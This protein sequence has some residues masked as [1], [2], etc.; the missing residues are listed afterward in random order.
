MNI[1]QYF[2]LVAFLI[3][4][5]KSFN[6][7]IDA[8]KK[9]LQD[10]Y[11]PVTV[12][13]SA[14]N[15]SIAPQ[16]FLKGKEEIE[17]INFKDLHKKIELELPD[18][19][20]PTDKWS[21]LEFNENILNNIL[22]ILQDF[23]V[24]YTSKI[25]KQIYSNIEQFVFKCMVYKRQKCLN[26]KEFRKILENITEK[27]KEMMKFGILWLPISEFYDFNLNILLSK[28]LLSE[29]FIVE[30]LD[31]ENE[32]FNK[33]D[34]IIK[35]F[36]QNGKDCNNIRKKWFNGNFNNKP[37]LAFMILMYDDGTANCFSKLH[38]PEP[39][40]QRISDIKAIKSKVVEGFFNYQLVTRRIFDFYKNNKFRF[41]IK[42]SIDLWKLLYEM[43]KL[44]ILTRENLVETLEFPKIKS[45][46]WNQEE[47]D[48]H[49]K[50]IDSYHNKLL[51]EKVKK[52]FE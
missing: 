47:F 2:I 10:D 43:D 1:I 38:F 49:L 9:I 18:G 29:Y 3:V 23:Q 13:L 14:K 33:F 7:N 19:Q 15:Q 27:Y 20:F 39:K 6:I 35:D 48:N 41:K 50:G 42:S 16:T 46:E 24:E 22:D 45:L 51:Y 8:I 11:K 12:L 28:P 52:L 32:L 17:T 25:Q 5:V 21:K 34:S 31:G 37:V 44:E 40:E 26:D 30:I 36:H 4:L